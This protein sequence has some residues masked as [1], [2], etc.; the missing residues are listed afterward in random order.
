MIE[1]LDC[2]PAGFKDCATG[3]DVAVAFDVNDTRVRVDEHTGQT[4][5]DDLRRW[6]VVLMSIAT[7]LRALVS[8]TGLVVHNPHEHLVFMTLRLASGLSLDR[9]AF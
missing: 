6:I 8:N 4:S 1:K 9:F 5:R 7:G 3:R 2:V